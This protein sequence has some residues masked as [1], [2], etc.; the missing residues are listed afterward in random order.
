MSD[1]LIRLAFALSIFH[2][3]V[4]SSDFGLTPFGLLPRHCSSKYDGGVLKADSLA[5]P[6]RPC[7]P[8]HQRGDMPNGWTAYAQWVSKTPVES[9][10]GNFTVPPV[11]GDRALQTIFLFTGLQNAM[12][13]GPDADVSII[14]PVLQWGKSAAGGGPYWSIASWFVGAQAVYSDLV[15]VNPGDTVFGNMTRIGN[16]WFID[17]YVPGPSAQHSSITVDVGATELYAFVTLEVYGINTCANFPNGVSVFSG[18]EIDGGSQTPEWQAQTE[19]EC[20]EAVK[21]VNPNQV[22]IKF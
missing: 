21:I 13:S 22:V 4:A 16:S 17:A 15:R 19:R 10:L 18:L 6:G 14:Q 20:S 7:A 1:K 12:V 5:K 11:P 3:N 8:A 2:L 9:F